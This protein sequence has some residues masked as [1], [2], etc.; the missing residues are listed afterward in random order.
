MSNQLLSLL[1]FSFLEK[2]HLSNHLFNLFHFWLLVIQRNKKKMFSNETN[3]TNTTTTCHPVNWPLTE[4]QIDAI[5]ITF[6]CVLLSIGLSANGLILWVLGCS[7]RSPAN[8]IGINQSIFACLDAVLCL[9]LFVISKAFYYIDK[10]VST[11]LFFLNMYSFM[12]NWI[13]Q[14]L[15]TITLVVIRSAQLCQI[16]RRAVISIRV[17]TIVNLDRDPLY[18]LYIGWFL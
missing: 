8:M 18:P 6:K 9:P 1:S 2:N 3:S 11:Y 16:A 7:N 5:T 14:S 10:D 4:S 15:S 17:R 12:S 13:F